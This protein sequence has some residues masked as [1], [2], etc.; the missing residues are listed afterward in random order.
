MPLSLELLEQICQKFE[1]KISPY[2]LSNEDRILATIQDIKEQARNTGYIDN[3]A[4][5]KIL[6][7]VLNHRFNKQQTVIDTVVIELVK[8]I[9]VC[10]DAEAMIFHKKLSLLKDG[11]DVDVKITVC[12]LRHYDDAQIRDNFKKIILHGNFTGAWN[13]I[14][15][16]TILLMF[17]NKLLEEKQ[18]ALN[19]RVILQGSPENTLK[20]ARAITTLH[21]LGYLT[22]EADRKYLD[23]IVQGGGHYVGNIVDSLIL[24][25]NASIFD[26]NERQINLNELFGDS[27]FFWERVLRSLELL[28]ETNLL[29]NIQIGKVVFNAMMQA[30]KENIQHVTRNLCKLAQSGLMMVENAPRYRDLIVRKASNLCNPAELIL[31]LHDANILDNNIDYIVNESSLYIEIAVDCLL[32]V[33]KAG[34]GQGEK[35]ERNREIMFNNNGRFLEGI[36]EAL[37]ALSKKNILTQEY[38][39]LV[40]QEDGQY[41]HGIASCLLFVLN[42]PILKKMPVAE[43]IKHGGIHAENM[44]HALRLLESNSLLNQEYILMLVKGS[45]QYAVNIARALSV[46]QYA[47]EKFSQK[48]LAIITYKEGKYSENIAESLNDLQQPTELHSYHKYLIYRDGEYAIQISQ[49]IFLLHKTKL[50]SHAILRSILAKTSSEIEALAKALMSLSKERLSSGKSLLTPQHARILLEQSQLNRNLGPIVQIIIFILR[51]SSTYLDNIP[52]IIQ[53]HGEDSHHLVIALRLLEKNNLLERANIDIVIQRPG[54]YPE[55][56]AT[57]LIDLHQQCLLTPIIKNAIAQSNEEH[58][59]DVTQSLKQLNILQLLSG[60]HAASNIEFIVKHNGRYA[61]DISGILAL[62][63]SM[64]NFS[65]LPQVVFDT[66]IQDGGQHTEDFG[67]FLK[68]CLDKEIFKNVTMG[69]TYN[70]IVMMFS[71]HGSEIKWIKSLLGAL[72]HHS[73]LTQAHYVK[74]VSYINKLYEKKLSARCL[75]ERFENYLSVNIDKSEHNTRVLTGVL[76]ILIQNKDAKNIQ[77]NQKNIDMLNDISQVVGAI[78]SNQIPPVSSCAI[79]E[80]ALTTE[81]ELGVAS[82]STESV[83]GQLLDDIGEVRSSEKFFQMIDHLEYLQQIACFFIYIH[84]NL[85]EKK[86]EVMGYVQSFINRNSPISLKHFVLVLELIDP[87]Q[88]KAKEYL[89]ALLCK[90]GKIDTVVCEQLLIYLWTEIE[91]KKASLDLE[92]AIDETFKIALSEQDVTPIMQQRFNVKADEITLG[93]ISNKRPQEQDAV[94]NASKIPRVL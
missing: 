86:P 68:I 55:K 8:L 69:E 52:G 57:A 60:V 14:Q 83:S 21:K 12:I 77:K 41:A 62:F 73:I 61:R 5:A 24:I 44:H 59:Q 1:I 56:V 84:S 20:I 15:A 36:Y 9:L 25:S 90:L 47:R 58:I 3:I 35:F 6:I 88:D 46:K 65:P 29:H 70:H 76:L 93:F 19:L 40:A 66:I 94:P 33:D 54:P 28:E 89:F 43:F 48:D 82:S 92:T 32:I 78:L 79:G 26:S 16:L 85:A 37:D 53:T 22:S 30:P 7:S 4:L 67:L 72:D 18:G 50:L 38:F 51:N 31:K 74:L 42:N 2:Y 81:L 87:I 11:E 49:I 34:L 45:G 17:D 63:I 39:D 91:K 80:I 71:K 75:F 13:L 27:P 64:S 23:F 10:D